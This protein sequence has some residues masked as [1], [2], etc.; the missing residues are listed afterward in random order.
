MILFQ[1]CFILY[2]NNLA[3]TFGLTQRHTL[4]VEAQACLN[5][6]IPNHGEQALLCRNVTFGPFYKQTKLHIVSSKR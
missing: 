4:S 6:A 3:D 2:R 5:C 1:I